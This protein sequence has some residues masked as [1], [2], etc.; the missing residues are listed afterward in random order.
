VFYKNF[1]PDVTRINLR[2]HAELGEGAYTVGNHTTQRCLLGFVYL[3]AQGNAVSADGS[4]FIR[5]GVI[6][7]ISASGNYKLASLLYGE[8]RESSKVNLF[9]KEGR[10]TVSIED[11]GSATGFVTIH[12][13][14]G[15]LYPLKNDQNGILLRPSNGELCKVERDDPTGKAL[16]PFF[17]KN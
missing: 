14:Y 12:G 7:A 15:S 2:Y 4:L 17:H 3:T 16:W 9:N 11:A 10:N 6:S 8:D 5:D 1:A 13:K